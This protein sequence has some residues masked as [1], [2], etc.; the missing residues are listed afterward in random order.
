MKM[1][2]IKSIFMVCIALGLVMGSSVVSNATDITNPFPFPGPPNHPYGTYE[3]SI[4]ADEQTIYFAQFGPP[5]GDPDPN[6]PGDR[7]IF[8]SYMKD[9][10]W[11][12]PELL[13]EPI[14]SPYTDTEPMISA[15]GRTLIF[16]SNRP[17]G[18]GN[19]DLYI[20]KKKAGSE[21]WGEVKNMGYPF[22]TKYKD[23][24]LV[25]AKNPNGEEVAYWATKRP[26]EKGFGSGDILMSKK[27]ANGKWSE[28]VNAGKAVN[29]GQNQ[30]RFV[31]GIGNKIG[32]VTDHDKSHHQDF[33]VHWDDKTGQWVGPRIPAGWNSPGGQ[34]DGCGRFSPSGK[35]WIWSSGRDLPAGYSFPDRFNLYWLHTD[36]ILDYYWHITGIDAK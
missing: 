28:P 23:H 1:L 20:V 35:K 25:M 5:I 3:P 19:S 17:G 8:V 30:C 22:N 6:R 13:P 33:L 10:K 11:S 9:G 36:S 34:S 32:I 18:M 21:E 4:T 16:Q 26:L 7:D 31:P 12:T 14:N 2:P 29:T 24:C 15:D 27:L